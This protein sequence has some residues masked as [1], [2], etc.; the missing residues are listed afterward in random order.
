[1]TTYRSLDAL[2]RHRLRQWPQRPP[3]LGCSQEAWLRGRPSDATTASHPFLKFPGSERLRTLP[4]GLWLNFGGTPVEP[5]VDIF[6]IEACSSLPNLLDKRSRF[7]P[8]TQSLLAVCPVPWLLAPVMP[9]NTTPR[10]RV[11]GVL[12]HEPTLP[13]VLPIRD[14][15]VMYALKQRHYE[16]FAGSQLP[17]PHEYFLPM[18]ALTAKD[19]HED[20]TIQAFVGRATAAANFLTA[21]RTGRAS[22]PARQYKSLLRPTAADAPPHPDR[23]PSTAAP[24][25][26]GSA[27]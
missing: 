26:P 24:T 15:R 12:R 16:G 8:S 14:I 27:P 25:A 18:D 19:A 6:A 7:A 1:M 13:L 9:G 20:P 10:W 4:D 23:S 17:H 22:G 5:F 21:A 3:G 2:V 11:T